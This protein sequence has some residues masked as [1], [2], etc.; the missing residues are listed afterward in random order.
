MRREKNFQTVRELKVEDLKLVFGGEEVA[1]VWLRPP[2]DGEEYSGAETV[3]RRV[4]PV[5]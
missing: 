3:Y 5:A 4:E 2:V 1:H